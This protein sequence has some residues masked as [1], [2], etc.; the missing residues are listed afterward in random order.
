MAFDDLDAYMDDNTENAAEENQGDVLERYKVWLQGGE[1]EMMYDVVLQLANATGMTIEEFVWRIRNDDAY[2]PNVGERLTSL[3]VT[4]V[5]APFKE[6][7]AYLKWLKTNNSTE[8]IRTFVTTAYDTWVD[9]IYVDMQLKTD[10]WT[11]VWN[12]IQTVTMPRVEE[13]RVGY[14]QA[15]GI[16]KD[17]NEA[18]KRVKDFNGWKN[19]GLEKTLYDMLIKI[20]TDRSDA[21]EDQLGKEMKDMLIYM[22]GWDKQLLDRVSTYTTKNTTRQTNDEKDKGII[23]LLNPGSLGASLELRDFVQRVYAFG[24]QLLETESRLRSGNEQWNDV[25]DVM[26]KARVDLQNKIETGSKMREI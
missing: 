14:K 2:N 6:C 26:N 22:D 13:Q 5:S 12:T 21:A 25:V 8:A 7:V 1:E 18:K 23:Q 3:K 11:T 15:L 19:S 9:L 10:N 24:Q 17:Q 4:G 16:M 20:F